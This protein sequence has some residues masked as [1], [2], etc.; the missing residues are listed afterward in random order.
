METTSTAEGEDSL[1][2]GEV[3][4]TDWEKHRPIVQRFAPRPRSE[5]T[6]SAECEFQVRCRQKAVEKDDLSLLSG[7]TE[8]ERKKWEQQGH[9]H[10]HAIV[11][12][13]SGHGAG[14]AARCQREKYHH[15]L[16][17]ARDS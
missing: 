15:S 9:L 6:L 16:K 14:P 8:K 11:L 2:R 4:K 7:K 3:R 12:H 5:S 17:A 1:W 10:R 13:L